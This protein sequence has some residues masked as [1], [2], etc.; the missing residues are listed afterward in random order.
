MSQA[1]T[2]PVK[3]TYLDAELNE[4]ELSAIGGKVTRISG[5]KTEEIGTVDQS[6]TPYDTVQA[7]LAS[8]P[9]EDEARFLAVLNDGLKEARRNAI[10]AAVE[11]LIPKD[12]IPADSYKAVTK[13][14]VKVFMDQGMDLKAARAKVEENVKASDVFKANIRMHAELT[15]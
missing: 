4:V 13:P 5:D 6:F 12:A 11:A 15:K 3:R 1:I 10:S 14:F 9:S 7:A 2:I 8:I